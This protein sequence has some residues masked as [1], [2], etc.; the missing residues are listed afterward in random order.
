MGIVP[1]R[2]GMRRHVCLGTRPPRLP[3]AFPRTQMSHFGGGS[4][5]KRHG[6]KLITCMMGQR[7]RASARFC[8]ARA[9]PQHGALC[10]EGLPLWAAIASC[11]AVGQYLEKNTKVGSFLSGPLMAIVMA[12]GA[13][14]LNIIPSVS[15]FYDQIWTNMLP[16]AA[17]LY[18]LET[19]LTR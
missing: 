4:S 15:L 8:R 5:T 18:V 7:G 2:E 9:L 16:I 11:A 10:A 12:M 13:S 6:L 14:T 19:D 17:A 3:V 1:G